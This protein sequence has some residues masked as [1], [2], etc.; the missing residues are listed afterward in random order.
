MAYCRTLLGIA[1]YF[2]QDGDVAKPLVTLTPEQ[3]H[4]LAAFVSDHRNVRGWSQEQVIAKAQRGLSKAPYS[5][6]ENAT[7]PSE[8]MARST[9]DAVGRVFDLPTAWWEKVLAGKLAAPSSDMID[10][11]SRLARL[12]DEGRRRVLAIIDEEEAKL[13]GRS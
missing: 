6:L 10:T 12:S 9:L 5:Q 11:H 4:T 7:Q 13:E 2:R 3:W 1:I 8:S